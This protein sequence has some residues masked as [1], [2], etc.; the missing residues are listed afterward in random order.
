MDKFICKFDM[1]YFEKKNYYGKPLILKYSLSK[2][3]IE[4]KI[5]S[6]K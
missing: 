5:E 2:L 4:Q 3:V 1:F 6:K